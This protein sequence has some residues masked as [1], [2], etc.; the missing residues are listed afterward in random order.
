MSCFCLL[1]VSL[2]NEQ[3]CTQD[4]HILPVFI[5]LAHV[6]CLLLLNVYYVY[7]FMF[8]RNCLYKHSL[9]S[10][11]RLGSIIVDFDILF[12]SSNVK[13]KDILVQASTDL[14]SGTNLTYDGTTVSAQIGNSSKQSRLLTNLL[15][16]VYP[17]KYVSI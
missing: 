14:A 11:Y 1:S 5:T 13:F 16:S 12:D 2:F 10:L 4:E 9:F 8:Q 17:G 3:S 7:C 6:S 15:W